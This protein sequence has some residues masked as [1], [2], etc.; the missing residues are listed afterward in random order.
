MIT[1][2][3]V[4]DAL[5]QTLLGFFDDIRPKW[6]LDILDGVVLDEWLD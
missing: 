2:K 6:A 4:L 5:T 3:C 1:R